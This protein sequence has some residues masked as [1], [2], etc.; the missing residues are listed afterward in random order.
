ME[1][2]KELEQAK[3]DVKTN[4]MLVEHCI[5]RVVGA[6]TVRGCAPYS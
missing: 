5:F 1:D 4:W 3:E 6:H 2:V